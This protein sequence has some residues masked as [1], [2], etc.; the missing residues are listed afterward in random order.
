[1]EGERDDEN[2]DDSDQE[3]PKSCDEESEECSRKGPEDGLGCRRVLLT[4]GVDV[5]HCLGEGR[6][7]KACQEPQY[8]GHSQK[9]EREV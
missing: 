1:M 2:D 6:N 8:D 4:V 5:S 3:D 9:D 7:G